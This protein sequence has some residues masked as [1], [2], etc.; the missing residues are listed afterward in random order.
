M[1]NW[2]SLYRVLSL[3]SKKHKQS[4][5]HRPSFLLA[6]KNR[7]QIHLKWPCRSLDQEITRFLRWL[8]RRAQER[9]F[10]RNLVRTLKNLEQIKYL[11]L[12]L[13]K[14]CTKQQ[15]NP[16]HLGGW[17][18]LNETKKLRSLEEHKT[19]LHQTHM[20]LCLHRHLVNR[21][22]GDLEP[23]K[24]QGCQWE[25]MRHLLCNRTIFHRGLLKDN[26]G[27]WD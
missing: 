5:S 10:I 9:L 13:I 16:S 27:S 26:A 12:D 7:D 14:T 21:R 1:R 19:F 25:K 17:V 8:V 3:T 15:R 23:G 6:R 11:V 24:E 22:S 2:Q 4:K 20:I 18:R